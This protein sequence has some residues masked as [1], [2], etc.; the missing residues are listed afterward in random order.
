MTAVRSF[1]TSGINDPATQKKKPEDLK[2]LPCSQ[3]QDESTPRHCTL[4][5]I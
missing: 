1:D 5:K 2:S 4:F 3:K